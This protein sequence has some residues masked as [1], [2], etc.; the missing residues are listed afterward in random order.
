MFFFLIV[1]ILQQQYYIFMAFSVK[2][3]KIF[4]D[5]SKIIFGFLLK[6]IRILDQHKHRQIRLCL[7]IIFYQRVLLCLFIGI[8]TIFLVL[9]FLL[10][11]K[12]II[13]LNCHHCLLQ[14]V[15]VREK[16]SKT[17]KL[18]LNQ[19]I[20]QGSCQE[21]FIFLYVLITLVL[22]LKSLFFLIFSHN[23]LNQAL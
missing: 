21:T 15:L 5:S 4:S 18:L 2:Y 6:R 20:E 1:F 22:A 23:Y 14:V 7:I 17:S 19:L 8:Q 9:H 16:S 12:L 13:L 10:N 11:F 3:L